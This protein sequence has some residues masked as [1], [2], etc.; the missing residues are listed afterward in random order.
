MFNFFPHAHQA[1]TSELERKLLTLMAEAKTREEMHKKALRHMCLWLRVRVFE[2]HARL[3]TRMSTRT[4][5]WC[6]C[7][8][9]IFAELSYLHVFITPLD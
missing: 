5:K 7:G 4:R 8:M 9:V 3:I 2:C 6:W 1:S